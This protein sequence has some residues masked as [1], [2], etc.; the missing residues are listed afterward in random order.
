MLNALS[1]ISSIAWK[2]TQSCI[3]SLP[4]TI[5]GRLTVFGRRPE[6]ANMGDTG[7]FSQ[8]RVEYNPEEE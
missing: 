8:G 3:T 2:F 5:F 6:Y 4:N 1:S 7:I